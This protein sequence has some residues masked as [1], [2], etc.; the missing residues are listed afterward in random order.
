MASGL[1][2]SW[3]RY[4]GSS[5]EARRCSSSSSSCSSGLA[6][7]RVKLSAGFDIGTRRVLDRFQLALA[8]DPRSFRL[9]RR[10]ILLLQPVQPIRPPA[11]LMLRRSFDEGLERAARSVID[12][13]L[14]LPRGRRVHDACDMA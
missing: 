13:I 14:V 7:L 9:Y 8:R 3:S 1:S 4:S 6:S 12:P 2:I 5:S 10:A 11:A